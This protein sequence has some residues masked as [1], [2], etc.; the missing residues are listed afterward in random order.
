MGS[1]K[2]FFT[3]T[4]IIFSMVLQLY[5]TLAPRLIVNAVIDSFA[6]TPVYVL[7]GRALFGLFLYMFLHADWFHLLANCFA[8]WGVGRII[9]PEIGSKYTAIAFYTSAFLGG[10]AHTLLNPPSKLP[11]VGIS[12]GVF[13]LLA[14]LFLLMPFKSTLLLILPLPSVLVGVL[15]LSIEIAALMLSKTTWIAHDV[16]LVGFLVGALTA[17]ALGRK[18]ALRGLLVAVVIAASLYCIGAYF[19]FI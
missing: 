10:V 9:E 18:K 17:F 16:H 11:L 3:Y 7:Q 4:L 15:M 6:L 5:M 8:L 12:G 13:G 14:V 2:P 1:H 19:G